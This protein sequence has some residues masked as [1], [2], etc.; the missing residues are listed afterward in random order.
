MIKRYMEALSSMPIKWKLTLWSSAFIL[1]LFVA[2]NGLQYV[3][4]EKWLLKQD[5]TTV[6]KNANQILSYLQDD[7]KMSEAEIVASRGF[8]G[9]L[10]ERDQFIRILNQNG[11]PILSIAGSF[12]DQWVKPRL[13]KTVQTE[14]FSHDGDLYL[15]VR[16]PIMNP[17]FK[18]TLEVVRNLETNDNLINLILLVMIC[19]ALGAVLLSAWGGMMIAR[20]M[21][22][23]VQSL[24]DTIIKVKNEGIHERAAVSNNGDEISELTRIFNEMMEQLEQSFRQQKQ[25]VEDAS[26]ELRTPLTI[27]EGHLSVLNRWG[28]HDPAVLDESLSIFKQ[29]IRRL[30]LLVEELLLLSRTEREEQTIIREDICPYEIVTESIHHLSAVYPEYEFDLDLNDIMDAHISFNPNHFEQIMLILLDNA[31][32]YSEDLKRIE[33][34]GRIEDG[35]LKLRVRDYGIGIPESDVPFVFE[36]F[37]RVDKARSR[38]RGGNGLGLSI[39]QKLTALYESTITLDS[40]EGKGTSVYLN[41]PLM[42]A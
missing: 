34:A 6:G 13:V 29:E 10:N 16:S 20:K 22:R 14:Q 12:P 23:P 7:R 39:A 5:I 35:E 33:V 9:K 26:H 17:G 41:I 2:Y 37:Y 27:L 25:F 4:I 28:K 8:L 19:A 18:G 15:A 1:F 36:R 40:M 30:K 32:K 31:V 11:D 24:R 21:L 38:E 3:V 42:K